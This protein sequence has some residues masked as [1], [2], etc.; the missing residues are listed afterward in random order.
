[1]TTTQTTFMGYLPHSF[2]FA[3]TEEMA[4]L[5]IYAKFRAK[6]STI[7]QAQLSQMERRDRVVLLLLDG[8]RTLFDVSRLT[9]RGEPDIARTLV[10]LLASGYV[11]FVGA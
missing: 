8:R 2:P 4:Q 11:E 10:R 9:H 5:G 1:M 6:I 7:S 3:Q